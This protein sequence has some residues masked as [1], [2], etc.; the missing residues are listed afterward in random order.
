MS[1]YRECVS[2][3]MVW[4]F[5]LAKDLLGDIASIEEVLAVASMAMQRA[6]VAYEKEQISR[7]AD[8]QMEQNPYSRGG[9]SNG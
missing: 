5:N 7:A 6:D 2:E 4:A 9:K 3:E 8:A 1:Q